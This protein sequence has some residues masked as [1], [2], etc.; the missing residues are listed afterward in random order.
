MFRDDLPLSFTIDPKAYSKLRGAFNQILEFVIEKENNVDVG[1][2][3]EMWRKNSGTEAPIKI[4]EDGS[5]SE[6]D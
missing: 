3:R 1:Y 4:S 2:Q 5:D 6:P